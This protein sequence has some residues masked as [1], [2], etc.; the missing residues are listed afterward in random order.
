MSQDD[1][2]IYIVMEF[3]G[4]GELFDRITASGGFKEKDAARI[5]RQIL[6]GELQTPWAHSATRH[7]RALHCPAGLSHMHGKGIAHCDLKPDNFLFKT[8][9][10]EAPL[11]IIDFGM[12]KLVDLR[13]RNYFQKFCGT[14]YYVAPEVIQ[15]RYREPC[16]MWSCGVVLFVML[17]GYPPFY[18]D[19]KDKNADRK[20]Y[21]L[22]Q[23]GFYAVEKD[24]YGPHFSKVDDRDRRVSSSVLTRAH[25][26]RSKS[27]SPPQRA[28]SS[29]A[30][31]SRTRR[32]ASRRK[33]RWRTRGFSAPPRRTC[34][35]RCR[36]SALSR[37]SSALTASSSMLWIL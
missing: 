17:H 2:N 26:A 8:K 29:R 35:S 36:C 31:W 3:C 33:R 6:E 21:E 22:I 32:S 28:A 25:P 16:D 7:S 13:R 19:P 27:P 1:E 20:I 9:E 10:P 11:K 24:G 30:C 23:S 4:G 12:S 34:R 5:L 14:P 15:G 37:G 18:A